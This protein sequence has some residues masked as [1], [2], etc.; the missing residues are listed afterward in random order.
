ML[1]ATSFS[2][3]CATTPDSFLYLSYDLH[4]V[5]M[6]LGKCAAKPSDLSSIPGTHTVEESNGSHKLPSDLHTHA[7]AFTHKSK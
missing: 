7:P 1:V 4:P 2:Y 5:D 6:A 3:V